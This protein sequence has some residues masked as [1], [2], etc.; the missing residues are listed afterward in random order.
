MECH[1]CRFDTY[2]Q[3]V[4]LKSKLLRTVKYL[5]MKSLP[6]LEGGGGGGEMLTKMCAKGASCILGKGDSFVF[7]LEYMVFRGEL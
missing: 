7:V 5:G 1:S 6:V 4:L 2:L 3:Y